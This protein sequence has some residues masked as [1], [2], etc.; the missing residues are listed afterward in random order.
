MSAVAGVGG[1]GG[2]MMVDSESKSDSEAGAAPVAAGARAGGRRRA[3]A[4]GHST[5]QL[6]TGSETATNP[7]QM[8][9]RTRGGRHVTSRA[10]Q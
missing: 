1:A 7:V 5:F 6:A 9:G 8:P 2:S 3:G 10:C 4:V